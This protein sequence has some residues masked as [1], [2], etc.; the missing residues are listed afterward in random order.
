MSVGLGAGA[1][2]GPPGP[3]LGV[4]PFIPGGPPG[5]A[6]PADPG[7]PVGPPA[8]GASPPT[9]S[10]W[11]CCEPVCDCGACCWAI[12]GAPKGPRVTGVVL[13]LPFDPLPLGVEA[14]PGTPDWLDCC[15]S[16]DVTVVLDTCREPEDLRP[17]DDPGSKY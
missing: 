1:G 13:P 8:P 9:P 16:V 14:P 2:A 12:E 3:L 5:P 7:G 11:G 6:G 4:G 15:A 10:G 17:L